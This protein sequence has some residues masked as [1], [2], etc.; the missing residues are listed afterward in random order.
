MNQQVMAVVV[1]DGVGGA[2]PVGR[3]LR[4]AYGQGLRTMAAATAVGLGLGL[5]VGGI[6]SRLAMRALFL[7]SDP[8][9]RGIISDD[10]FAIGR[11]DAMATL[12]LLLV[13]TV[14]G[15]IG[16][17]VYLAVRP[18]LIGPRWLRWTT[19][20][21]AAGAVVGSL[22]VHVDGVDFTRLGPTWFAIALFVSLPALFG[23]LAPP[24]VEWAARPGGWFRSASP[25]VA[26]LPLLALLFPPLLVLVGIPSAAVIGAHHLAHRSAARSRVLRH[27]VILWTVRAG[28]LGVA[29]LGVVALA[30][31]TIALL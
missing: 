15:I 5:M 23:L 31:D 7:T 28:W 18:F 14:V 13:G 21:L 20:A 11:F 22:L 1:G 12:N 29:L 17:F 16:A 25:R 4:Q 19:C 24:A 3:S 2:A 10:G 26:L 9:V 8:S 6:G 27:P 30:R